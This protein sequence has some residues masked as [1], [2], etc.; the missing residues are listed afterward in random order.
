MRREP[1]PRPVTFLFLTG[2]ERGLLGAAFAAAHPPWPLDRIRALINLDGGAPPVPPVSW[3]I[4]G[5]LGSPIGATA[6]SI[7]HSHDWAVLLTAGRPN[8]DYWPFLRRGVQ[9]AFIIPG[10]EW[11]GTTT[12]Q[13]DSLRQKWD[14]YH[15]RDDEYHAD[16]PFTGIARYAQLAY[17]LGRTLATA[18]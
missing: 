7:A 1:P 3:R 13:R 18:H 2:E 17:E 14:R 12:A 15:H 9:S 6:D 4:A 10:N 11:E 5:A 8:S 16:F